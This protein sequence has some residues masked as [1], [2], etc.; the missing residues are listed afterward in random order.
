MKEEELSGKGPSW[1]L[2]FNSRSGRDK[3]YIPRKIPAYTR[4][5]NSQ[6]PGKLLPLP[7]LPGTEENLPISFVFPGTRENLP[8]LYSPSTGSLLFNL[9]RL[10]LALTEGVYLESFV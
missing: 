4:G 7:V 5:V 6:D 9:I 1:T 2:S 8:T 10:S 3:L